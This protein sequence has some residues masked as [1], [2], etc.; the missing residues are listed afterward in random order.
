MASDKQKSGA[1]QYDQARDRARGV[2]PPA[3]PAP[4]PDVDLAP[5]A[6]DPPPG[7]IRRAETARELADVFRGKE[8][9]P[10]FIS[11]R[12]GDVISGGFVRFGE[13][14]LSEI[15]KITGEPKVAPT[16]VMRCATEIGPALVEF[17]SAHEL[18]RMLKDAE[19]RMVTI[20]RGGTRRIDG[21]RQVTDY[22]VGFDR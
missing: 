6:D 13:V 3:T 14:P 10:R 17:L 18:S 1:A 19:G 4:T 11:L 20:A 5:A 9:A 22:I 15:D 12:E 2:S 16:V 8:M 21:G 7:L